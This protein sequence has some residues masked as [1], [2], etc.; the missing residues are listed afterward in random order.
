MEMLLLG[1]TVSAREAYRLGLVNKVVQLKELLPVVNDMA[2][3]MASS[4]P[5]ALRYVRE[6][7]YKGLDLTLEQGLR[8]E[9]DLYAILQTTEDR[10]EGITSFLK[11]RQ[12]KFKGK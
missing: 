9:T 1:E 8:L 7:V 12:P 4:A 5:L 6:A 10:A 3:R 11:K 2:Q